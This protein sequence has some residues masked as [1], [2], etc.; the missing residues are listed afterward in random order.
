MVSFIVFVCAFFFFTSQISLTLPKT[1]LSDSLLSLVPSK[2]QTAKIGQHTSDEQ[3]FLLFQIMVNVA[4]S[5][6]FLKLLLLF[7]FLI[8]AHAIEVENGEVWTM[9]RPEQC[10][11][12]EHAE[13]GKGSGWIITFVL[14]VYIFVLGLKS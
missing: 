4:V 13:S 8:P 11:G 9:D 1:L 3:T 2:L 12:P 5:F 10:F 7:F 14:N 6:F